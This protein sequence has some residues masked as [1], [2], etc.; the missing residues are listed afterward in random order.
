MSS[1]L[2][3]L[4]RFS[5]GELQPEVRFIIRVLKAGEISRDFPLYYHEA[6]KVSKC[7]NW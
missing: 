2:A 3:L 7:M 1:S 4:W 6:S 5:V